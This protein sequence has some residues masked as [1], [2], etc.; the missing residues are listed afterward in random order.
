MRI[1]AF[2]HAYNLT[3]P[4]A[5]AETAQENAFPMVEQPND[6]TRSH[7]RYNFTVG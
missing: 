4:Y 3:W 6:D 1:L 5:L 2:L 7:G